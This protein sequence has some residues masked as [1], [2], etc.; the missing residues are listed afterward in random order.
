MYLL[1]PKCFQLKIVSVLSWYELRQYFSVP[2]SVLYSGGVRV[3]ETDEN[4]C[5]C[6]K[7]DEKISK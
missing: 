5:Q 6:K 4:S 7:V 2:G 1:L 3:N